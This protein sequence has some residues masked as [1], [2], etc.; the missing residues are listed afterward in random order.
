MRPH[1]K[2]YLET[3]MVRTGLGAVEIAA[4][5]QMPLRTLY[6]IR[7]R[8]YPLR[9]R[10]PNRASL[11]RLADVLHIDL[12]VLLRWIGLVKR[13]KPKPNPD[14][15]LPLVASPCPVAPPPVAASELPLAPA[16]QT[17]ASGKDGT[18]H[19]TS[20]AT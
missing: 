2:P 8:V 7:T 19:A 9:A 16:T 12:M 4:K 20:Q 10:G 11:Q 1:T 17:A 15:A 5:A 14:T 13:R 3:A 6:D 18:A